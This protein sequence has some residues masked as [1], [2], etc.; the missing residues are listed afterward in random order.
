VRANKS[1]ELHSDF[2]RQ[3]VI[4]LVWCCPSSVTGPSARPREQEIQVVAA[5]PCGEKA[6]NLWAVS[7]LGT[8]V[9]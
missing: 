2:C 9:S 3:E 1:R 5:V 8:K 6:N 7:W 4:A